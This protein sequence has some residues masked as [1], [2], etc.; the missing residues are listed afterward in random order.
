MVYTNILLLV[1]GLVLLLKGSEWL[2]KSASSFAKKVGISEFIIGLTVVAFGTSIPELFSAII[3]SF[4]QESGLVLGNIIGANIANLGLIIGL[5]AILSTLKTSRKIFLREGYI[6]IFTSLMF[7]VFLFDRD[8][9]RIEAFFMILL[10]G[11]YTLF[12]FDSKSKSGEK[13]TFTGFTRYFLEFR[14]FQTIFNNVNYSLKLKTKT[15]LSLIKDA[16]VGMVSL[17]LVLLGANTIVSQGIFFANEFSVSQVIIGIF[18]SIGTTLPELSVALTAIKTGY[19]NIAI[20]NAIG[21][22]ITNTLLI[23]GIAGLISPLAVP[24]YIVRFL[25]PAMVGMVLLFLWFLKNDWKISR[26][27]GIIL[28]GLYLA[29]MVSVIIGAIR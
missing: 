21:S 23:I 6:L 7:F 28:L 2:V 17:A 26:L 20:G 13:S 22:C 11:T 29:F 25:A 27:E 1:A 14:Y 15:I 3:A 9:N 12:L 4:K 10:Y 18:L 8:I 24:S 19:R 16:L 5:A